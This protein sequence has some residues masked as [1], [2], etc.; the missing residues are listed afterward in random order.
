M[1][2][3]LSKP[4]IKD[5]WENLKEFTNARIALGSAGNAIPLKEVLQFKFAHAHSKDA[6][7]TELDMETLA[8][9]IQ[10]W[11]YPIWEVKSQ[12]SDRLEYLKRPD[13]GRKL[14]PES[15]MM[16]K[17][18]NKSLDIIFVLADGLSAGAVNQNALPLL[19]LLL[20][21]LQGYSIGFVTATM[22]RVALGDAI[23]S[24]LNAKFVALFI[25]E[26]PGLS[27][28]ESMGIYTTY[29][30]KMGLTDERRNC[31]SNIHKNGLDHLQAASLVGYLIRQSFA[32]KISGVNIKINLKDLLED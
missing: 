19:Q 1:K 30:P 5:P 21:Q 20:P 12:A 4:I 31:I 24:V 14:D 16:L 22:A 18:S 11:G 15:E 25:G 7:T 2:E 13:L 17:K 6:I 28:P 32:K 9:E 8:T 27:S 29:A 10:A 23:G 26:R 3:K